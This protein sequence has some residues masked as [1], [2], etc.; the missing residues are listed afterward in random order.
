MASADRKLPA[1]AGVPAKSRL[2]VKRSGQRI[3]SCRL[4]RAFR[5]SLGEVIASA[6]PAK[7][8]LLLTMSCLKA[9]L[10]PA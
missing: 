9:I 10:R 2:L 3:E 1:E 8:D 6:A 5:P 4:K 7:P